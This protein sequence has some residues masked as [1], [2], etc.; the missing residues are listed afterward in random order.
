MNLRTRIAVITIFVFAFIIYEFNDLT[1][2]VNIQKGIS[3]TTLLFDGNITHYTT[4]W[5]D[6]DMSHIETIQNNVNKMNKIIDDAIKLNKK[7]ITNDL[8]LLKKG[9]ENLTSKAIEYVNLVNEFGLTEKDG[10]RGA[11]RDSIHKVEAE[12]DKANNYKLGFDMLMLRRREKDF[13]IRGDKQY[14]DKWNSDFKTIITD[15][16]K[17]NINNSLKNS[18]LKQLELYKENFIQFTELSLKIRSIE[19][20]FIDLVNVQ[21]KIINKA[22]EII[23]N[24]K[25]RI[26]KYV[27]IS[28]ISGLL[29]ILVFFFLIVYLPIK[30]LIKPIYDIVK[31]MKLIEKGNFKTYL[32]I[33]RN[34]ELGIL[35]TTIEKVTQNLRSLIKEIRDS[36][37]NLN[38][39][40]EII[41]TKV[42]DVNNAISVINK[43]IEK[44]KTL[45][46][47]QSSSVEETSAAIEQMTRNIDSLNDSIEEQASSINESSAAIEEMVSN[48]QQ[49]TRTVENAANSVEK[50]TEAS[51]QGNKNI[52]ILTKLVTEIE[53][54]SE[55][56]LETNKM[57]A[58]I[59]E[60]T[61]L[62]AMNAAIEAAHAG[63]ADRK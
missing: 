34:D 5:K 52:D 40:S 61:N 23:N 29:I 14:I 15:V 10:K 4:F 38:S 50:L 41:V 21:N 60:K 25:N 12:I 43:N 2:Y 32:S 13:I 63:N 59:S 44:E 3:I 45:L 20:G 1:D 28:I 35:T 37:L 55:T 39:I 62:L 47:D 42:G 49:V 58:N 56:L 7:N 8:I 33:H 53:S 51:N 57:I 16:K 46:S 17:S 18:I 27:Y 26:Q 9:Y 6:H 31:H 11:F 30:G 22:I 54:H 36:V 24:Q 48:I 19:K